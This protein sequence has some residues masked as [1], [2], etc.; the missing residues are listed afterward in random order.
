MDIGRAMLFPEMNYTAQAVFCSM[1]KIGGRA[2][3]ASAF[4][5]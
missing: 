2:C 1:K 4:S 3:L 5:L